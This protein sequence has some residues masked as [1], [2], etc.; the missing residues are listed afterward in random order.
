[1]KKFLSIVEA[2]RQPEETFDEEKVEFI[3]SQI[4]IWDF[5]GVPQSSYLA[6]SIE[7]KSAIF[8]QYYN[9]LVSEYYGKSVKLFFCLYCFG[10]LLLFLSGI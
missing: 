5:F 10:L 7:E 6:L 8:N 9:K 1:M 2:P 3:S 4:T